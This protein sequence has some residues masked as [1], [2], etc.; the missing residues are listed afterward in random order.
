[1]SQRKAWWLK[2]LKIYWPLNH[3]MAKA[4]TLPVVGPVITKIVD[5]FFN[6][7]A[8]NIT[9]L[10]VNANID[11]AVSTT[12]TQGVIAELIRRSSHRVLIK[13]CTCRDAK[14]CQN[15]PIEDACMLLGEDTARISPELADHVS[16]EE[17]LAHLDRLVAKGLIPMTGRVRMDDLYWG[18]PNRGRMLT[19]CFCC[20]C[21]CTVMAS[22]RYFPDEIRKRVVPVKGMHVEVDPVK[23]IG[24]GTCE[25][26]CLL[27]AIHIENGISVHDSEKCIG[28]GRCS[29]VCPQKATTVTVEDVN[30]AVD[31]ILGR[32]RER[33]TVE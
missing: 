31:E 6:E 19:I 17:A 13:R 3:A 5:P 20:P 7:K 22:T 25:N 27:N 14:N 33:V 16:V 32:I 28:C 11:P 15:F 24:C 26:E 8:F 1:M 18:V 2:A 30:A 29:I 21:C 10:P 4:T 23:C 9:Y 12:L